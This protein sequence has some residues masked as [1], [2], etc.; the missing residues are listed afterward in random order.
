MQTNS[1]SSAEKC[2]RFAISFDSSF[3]RGYGN[4]GLL[5]LSL[6]RTSEALANLERAASLAPHCP[7][8][9]FNLGICHLSLGSFDSG[10]RFYQERL[11]TTLVPSDSWPTYGPI[12]N[13]LSD[14][15]SLEA[16]LVVWSEQG[17]GDTIQF[18]RYLRLLDILDVDYE[19]HCNSPLFRLIR[20]WL[21]PS[22]KVSILHHRSDLDDSRPH[23][24]LLSMPFLFESDLVT[25]PSIVPYLHPPLKPDSNLI[26]QKPSGGI[27]VGLVWSSNSNN[28]RMYSKKSCPINLLLPLLLN[29]VQL[30]LIDIHSLQVGPDKSFLN[31]WLEHERIYDWSHQISDFSDTAHIVQ[32]LDLVITVDTAVAHLSGALGRPTWLLLPFDPDFRWLRDRDDS[33][34]YPSCLKLFRQS[35]FGDWSS[36]VASL[37]NA[38]EMLF[39]VNINSLVSAK[40][41][42]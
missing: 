15:L 2:F 41:R 36:V 18:C 35:S 1:F 9:L 26:V 13:N 21:K 34:W 3:S 19:F 40:L 5:L 12:V 30:D 14:L 24:P 7:D 10:W 16:P 8:T 25:I 38:C 20:D 42:K 11:N 6:G 4:L 33:P 32:Q 23:C 37:Y 27:S 28:S 39:M 31:P 29:L 22:A 17:F